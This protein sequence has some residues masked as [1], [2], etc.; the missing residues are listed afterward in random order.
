MAHFLINDGFFP[1]SD[2]SEWEQINYLPN[3]HR[4]PS[5]K[6]PIT[7]FLGGTVSGYELTFPQGGQMGPLTM[8]WGSPS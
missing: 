8:F 2:P 5:M 3:R 1:L 7:G 4:R 6:T